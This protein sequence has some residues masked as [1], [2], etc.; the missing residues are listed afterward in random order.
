MFILNTRRVLDTLIYVYR[1]R[2]VVLE[3]NLYGPLPPEARVYSDLPERSRGPVGFTHQR[4][5]PENS[6]AR[7]RIPTGDH[8]CSGSVREAWIGRHT[9][10]PIW[11]AETV[12]NRPEMGGIA[13]S[14]TK[15]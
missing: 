13:G 9:L 3:A 1:D 14:G 15:Q 11:L 2:V 6:D 5:S 4:R 7:S 12:A 8:I 10:S